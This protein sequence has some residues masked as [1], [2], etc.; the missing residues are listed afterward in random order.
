MLNGRIHWINL[1]NDE[2]ISMIMLLSLNYKLFNYLSKMLSIIFKILK[3]IF[4]NTL[5]SFDFHFSIFY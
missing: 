2:E 3:N 1:L 4:L 5:I